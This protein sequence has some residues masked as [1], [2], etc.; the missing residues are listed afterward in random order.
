ME[1]EG[2]GD[3]VLLLKKGFTQTKKVDLCNIAVSVM[4]LSR[5]L[6]A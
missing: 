1:L 4:F 6:L 2:V 5:K 3:A